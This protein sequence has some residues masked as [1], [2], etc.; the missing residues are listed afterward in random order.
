MLSETS[1][2]QGTTNVA[3]ASQSNTTGGNGAAGLAA[4]GSSQTGPL[5]LFSI[6]LMMIGVATAKTA[7]DRRW[8]P[9]THPGVRYTIDSKRRRR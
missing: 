5:V 2:R 3:G 6:G 9:T 7:L 4:T 1:G 8:I